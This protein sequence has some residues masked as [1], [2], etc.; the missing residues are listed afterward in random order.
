M[1][2]S[3]FTPLS[4]DRPPVLLPFFFAD[5]Q[6]VEGTKRRQYTPSEPRAE[7]SLNW[8]TGCM[9]LDL[10]NHQLNVIPREKRAH[11]GEDTAHFVIQPLAETR[12]L[13]SAACENDI[14]EELLPK[15]GITCS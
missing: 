7:T 10:L 14:S 1:L 2:R 11:P 13:A 5:P 9:Y 8:I 12:E 4:N 6:L 15:L 3:L